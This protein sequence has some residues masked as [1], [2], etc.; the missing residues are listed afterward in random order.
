MLHR[1]TSYGAKIFPPLLHE[2]WI[3]PHEKCTP[4]I[5]SA[6]HYLE[7]AP[8]T[9]VHNTMDQL[10]AR[11]CTRLLLFPCSQVTG[12]T[13]Y[14]PGV[15]TFALRAL[16]Y[17]MKSS[18]FYGSFFALS[19]DLE[20][21]ALGNFSVAKQTFRRWSFFLVICT[22]EHVCH[23]FE[24]KI[25]PQIENRGRDDICNF[26]EF[27]STTSS[28]RRARNGRVDLENGKFQDDIE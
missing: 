3:S 2:E 20:H 26:Q 8:Q 1:R 22:L 24:L 21:F 19:R 17:T 28:A 5:P 14:I 4:F 12:T 25:R 11:A 23:A 9:Y 27:L 7:P 6:L 10:V 15:E 16:R 13:D 18:V